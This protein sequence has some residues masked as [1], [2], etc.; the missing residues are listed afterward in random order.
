MSLLLSGRA[1][2]SQPAADH[3]S[4]TITN[5]PGRAA[6]PSRELFGLMLNAFSEIQRQAKRF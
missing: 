2:Q 1:L 3:F 5:E 6:E 4:R